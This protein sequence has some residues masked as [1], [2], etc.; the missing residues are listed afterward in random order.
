MAKGVGYA[1]DAGLQRLMRLF[2]KMFLWVARRRSSCDRFE[3]VEKI[4]I[5][6][7]VVG[8]PKKPVPLSAEP[9]AHCQSRS[10]KVESEFDSRRCWTNTPPSRHS[11]DSIRPAAKKT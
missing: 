6:L 7:S 9:Q 11:A 3:D 2:G 4:S 1:I 5:W 10:F 8:R